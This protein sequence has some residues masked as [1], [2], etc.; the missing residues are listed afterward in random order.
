MHEFLVRS[1]TGFVYS[2]VIGGTFFFLPPI[3]FSLLLGGVAGYSMVCEWP[4]LFDWRGPAFWLLMPFY[5][6]FSFMLL[7]CLNQQPD[8]RLLIPVMIALVASNDTGAYIVGKMIGRHKL[9]PHISPNKTWEGFIGGYLSTCIGLLLI[10]PGVR[11]SWVLCTSLAAV[12]A[13]L[14]TFGDLFES[15]LKRHAGVKDSG[16]I[17]PGHGGFIDRLDS[18]FFAI[19]FFYP[20]RHLLMQLL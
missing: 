4:N 9:C 14:A 19:F 20:A 11:D 8:Y 7:I 10:L 16:C 3:F 18:V 12:I 1:L 6:L 2:A 13:V 15:M 17:L 5:P